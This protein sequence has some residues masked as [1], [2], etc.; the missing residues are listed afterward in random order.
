MCYILLH[1]IKYRNQLISF[2]LDTTAASRNHVAMV[3]AVYDI[4]PTA[5][6]WRT[7]DGS[8][9]RF[10]N[11]PRN[12]CT[13][14]CQLSREPEHIPSIFFIS[15]F[16]CNAI[17]VIFVSLCLNCNTGTPVCHCPIVPGFLQSPLTQCQIWVY[18]INLWYARFN[19]LPT[20]FHHFSIFKGNLI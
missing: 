10:R 18:I 13:H 1:I 4:I 15:Q 17:F 5:S 19:P 3:T 11:T 14:I 7:A 12:T 8:R 16:F 2:G 20:V 6:L 9:P